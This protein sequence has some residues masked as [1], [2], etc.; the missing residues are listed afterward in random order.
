MIQRQHLVA[1]L[2]LSSVT[3]NL[4]LGGIL[5]GNYLGKVSEPKLGHSDKSH[6]LPKLHWMIQSL[7]TES[8]D[9]IRP[10]LEESHAQLRQQMRRVKETRRAVHQQLTAP[11]LNTE[12]LSETLAKLRQQRGEARQIM[13]QA[14]IEIAS[15]LDAQ[16]RQRL[17]EATR[18]PPHWRPARDSD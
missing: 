8:R 11:D 3:L 15:Q 9:K 4:F 14:L 5:V 17:S 1:I 18:K 7:P 2:L 10:I 16:D 13:H 12:A 6:R